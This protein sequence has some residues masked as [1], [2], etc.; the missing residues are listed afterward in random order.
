MND[1]I[2]FKVWETSLP[3]WIIHNAPANLKCLE[4]GLHF[5]IMSHSSIKKGSM[6]QAECFAQ[7][8]DPSLLHIMI[9]SHPLQ[10]GRC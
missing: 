6:M 10:L 9:R 1:I 3:S 4:F 7:V 2:K 5:P 8:C